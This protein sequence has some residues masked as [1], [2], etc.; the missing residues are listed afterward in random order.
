MEI[1]YLSV[2][3]SYNIGTTVGQYVLEGC[4]LFREADSSPLLSLKYINQDK[5]IFNTNLKLNRFHLTV[6]SN[7]RF[8]HIIMKTIVTDDLFSF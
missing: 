5:R 6:L 4:N 8:K 7:N 1:R 3:E 2:K